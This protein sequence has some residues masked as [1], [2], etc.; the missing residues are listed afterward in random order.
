MSN[1]VLVIGKSGSGKSSSLR[2]LNSEHTFIISVLDKPLPFKG[3]KKLYMPIK[4]WDDKEGNYLAT[5]D[6]QRIIKCIQMINQNR[7]EINTLII[8]DIQY[9]LA[10][11]F[12]KRSAERGFDKYSEMGMHYWSIINSAMSCRGNL[13][14]F[15]LSHNEIDSNGC[16]K[17]KTIGKMLD[18]KITIEG[19]FT[20]VLHT[21]VV[22]DEYLFLTQS[23]GIH[24]AKSPLGMFEE[25]LIE[26][27][28]SFVTKKLIEYFE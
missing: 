27:D 24:N 12:M 19:L 21:L 22:D 23:D 6:W 20:T 15:F 1:T 17:V 25:K 18:E 5:D 9:V 10:N 11:E 16:S 7:P 3:Y 13:L 8:D 14:T 26:N 2:N 28:L 4:G